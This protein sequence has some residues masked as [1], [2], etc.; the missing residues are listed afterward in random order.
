M[1]VVFAV[2]R[3]PSVS[4]VDCIQ[5][6]EDIVKLLSQHGSL[7]ILVFLTPRAGTQFPGKP[8]Q[9][10]RKIHAGRKIL[11]FLTEIAVYVG[12]GM[13]KAHGYYGT[14]TGSHR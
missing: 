13:R 10:R 3:C 2:V 11:R 5:T 1:R 7:T 6:A 14:L 8:L 4:P 9:Q 12:N